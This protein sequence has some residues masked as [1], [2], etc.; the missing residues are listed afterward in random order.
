P[1]H[2]PPTALAPTE[3]DELV[4]RL[5]LIRADQSAVDAINRPLQPIERLQ[6][7]PTLPASLI[8]QKGRSVAVA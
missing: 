2:P 1:S 5:M 3:V 8:K 4:L 6:R 7:I